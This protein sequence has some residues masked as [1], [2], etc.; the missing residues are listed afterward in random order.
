MT[1][2]GDEIPSGIIEGKLDGLIDAAL[3]ISSQRREI[4][5]R[6]RSA[7]QKG[8]DLAALKYARELCGLAEQ[9]KGKIKGDGMSKNQPTVRKSATPDAA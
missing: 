1:P 4:L 8:D 7:L 5:T 3:Q 9:R 2:I 6:M